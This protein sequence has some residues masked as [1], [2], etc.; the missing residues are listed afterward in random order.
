LRL[1][2]KN[3][4][5][6]RQPDAHA[7][8]SPLARGTHRKADAG[9]NRARPATSLPRPLK[10][11]RTAWKAALRRAGIKDFRWHDLRHTAASWWIDAGVP[12]DVV[13]E[14]L[15]HA[16]IVTTGR[17]AH[18]AGDARRRAVDAV[19]ARLR[20]NDPGDAPQTVDK[21]A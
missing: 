7:G 17:Y 19:A 8:S 1:R 16:S 9:A 15:G 3:D 12:L 20:H 21:K 18:R 2:T 13:K 14:L 4:Q 5:N 6:F 11:W 10:S